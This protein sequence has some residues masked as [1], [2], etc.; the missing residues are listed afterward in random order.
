MRNKAL[1]SIVLA[2]LVTALINIFTLGVVI[3]KENALLIGVFIQMFIGVLSIIIYNGSVKKSMQS[4]I[5]RVRAIS[6]GQLT[7]HVVDEGATEG[8][9]EPI[10]NIVKEL[11]KVVCE[12]AIVTQKSKVISE[13]LKV[14]ISQNEASA[15]AIA[16]TICHIAEGAVEQSSVTASAKENSIKMSENSEDISKHAEKTQATAEEMMAVVQESHKM[17]EQLTIKIRETANMTSKT[18]DDMDNLENEAAKI[19]QI[20]SAVTEI[21]ERTN[22]L[23]LNASIEAARAGEAGRGFAVVAEEVRKLAEQSASS[24][25]EIRQLIGAIVK[26]IH[27]LAE[28]TRSGSDKLESDLSSVDDAIYALSRVSASSKETYESVAEIM[29]LTEDSLNTVSA[30]NKSMERIN[31]SIQETAAGAEEVS[32]SSEELSASMQLISSM[33]NEM[34]LT[35]CEVDEYLKGFINKVAIDAQTKLG[36]QNGFNLLKEISDELVR[37]NISLSNASQV[38]REY[39]MKY[40]QFEYIGVLD[41]KGEMVSANMPITGS[42]NN[43]SHRPYFVEAVHGKNYSSDP[44]ISNVSFNYC[45]AIATSIKNAQGS[46]IAVIMADLCIEK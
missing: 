40:K 23:A 41:L 38:V 4:T 11:K 13:H 17:I 37:K 14:S 19:G 12:V 3:G 33:A 18:S 6:D 39:V 24:A 26:K 45:I 20:V 22:M 8:L 34:N 25:D 21:S 5:K 1:L 42:N 10:N 36:I 35:A 9:A 46:T 29:A 30:V 28:N 27:V 31:E 2:Q 32:A 44:Y 16:E 15:T 43:Y 7:L